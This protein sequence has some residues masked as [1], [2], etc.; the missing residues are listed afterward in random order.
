M[1]ILDDLK[2]QID[3]S[4]ILLD[5]M[6]RDLQY[7]ALLLS[8]ELLEICFCRLNFVTTRYFASGLILKF[9]HIIYI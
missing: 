8:S 3:A 6:L 9:S 7:R 1:L 2:T 5:D 4:L